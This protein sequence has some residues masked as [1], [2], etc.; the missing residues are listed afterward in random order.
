MKHPIIPS[1][2]IALRPNLK[3]E[4]GSDASV[5][6]LLDG[7]EIA[8]IASGKAVEL[9]LTSILVCLDGTKTAAEIIK[10]LENDGVKPVDV[11]DCLEFLLESG[12]LYQFEQSKDS[13]SAS[14][15]ANRTYQPQKILDCISKA[16]V[17]VCADLY[18]SQ[19]LTDSLAKTGVLNLSEI[20]YSDLEVNNFLLWEKQLDTADLIVLFNVDLEKVMSMNDWCVKHDKALVVGWWNGTKIWFGPFLVPHVTACQSCLSERL[21]HLHQNRIG[22]V[23]SGT[24]PMIAT[25]A[26][27]LAGLCV[28]FISG[29][30]MN[31]ALTSIHE[32]D[33][34]NISFQVH[35]TIK[36]PRCRVCSRLLKYPEGAII[37]E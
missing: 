12:F 24:L 8:D 17:L 32:V 35:S 37:N 33:L 16:E 21:Q 2:Y 14:Y 19:L 4:K 31:K 26:N 22:N 28:E 6:V 7:R 11:I 10:I 34:K 36:N 13:Y 9:I 29:A 27:L 5:A 1:Q 15:Y 3:I 20:P 23:R 30:V 18:F 25:A